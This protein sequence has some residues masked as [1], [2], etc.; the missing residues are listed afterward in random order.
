MKN[1]H[2]TKIFAALLAALSLAPTLAQAHPGH[3]SGLGAGLAHPLQGLD[4]VLAMV[5]V[6]LWAAQLGGRARWAVPAAFVTLMAAG[7]AVGMAGVTVPFVQPAILCSVVILGL[8]I[9]AA[10]RPPLVA[11][12][13]LVGVFAA[14][15]GLAHGGEVPANADGLAYAG[16]LVLATAGWHGC[17]LALAT[18]LKRFAEAGW[19]QVAG[20]AIVVGGAIVAVS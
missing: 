20:V 17:G 8:L 6:G 16:G 4:H 5:A 11:S 1:S 2:S 13:A 15:H 10:M 12:M 19:I 9:L 14:F 18:A 3:G 7:S